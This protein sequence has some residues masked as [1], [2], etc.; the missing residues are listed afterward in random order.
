MVMP[1]NARMQVCE[2]VCLFVCVF[3]LSDTET[4]LVCSVLL[5]DFEGLFVIVSMCDSVWVWV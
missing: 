4:Q 5:S 1:G 2:F 3:A